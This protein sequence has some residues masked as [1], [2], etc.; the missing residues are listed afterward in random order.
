[1]VLK[2]ILKEFKLLKIY[3]V[4]F[5]NQVEIYKPPGN[6]KEF[7][8]IIENLLKNY[9]FE[10]IIRNQEKEINE[11]KIQILKLEKENIE[12]KNN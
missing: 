9:D 4:I 7:I 10:M 2:I 12:L 11:L 5:N 3:N 1:M 6:L 8:K